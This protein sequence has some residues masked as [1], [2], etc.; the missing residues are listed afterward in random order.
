M[1]GAPLPKYICLWWRRRVSD[2]GDQEFVSNVKRGGCK[3]GDGSGPPEVETFVVV[4]GLLAASPICALLLVYH[5]GI[6]LPLPSLPLQSPNPLLTLLPCFVFLLTSPQRP[7]AQAPRLTYMHKIST[8]FRSPH[9]LC[10]VGCEEFFGFFGLCYWSRHGARFSWLLHP[11]Q[12]SGLWSLPTGRAQAFEWR[13]KVRNI[14][15][16]HNNGN[17]Q[18]V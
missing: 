3:A 14:G 15:T 11:P 7:K 17:P 13:K 12:E 1:G 5:H 8:H 16:R 10:M 6:C 18:E 4:F 2:D 9:P